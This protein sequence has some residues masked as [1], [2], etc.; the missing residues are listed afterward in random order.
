MS[1]Q[2]QRDEALTAYLNRY[3]KPAAILGGASIGAMCII[4]DLFNPMGNGD[5]KSVV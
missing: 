5:R 3:I 4:S 1:I 2:N